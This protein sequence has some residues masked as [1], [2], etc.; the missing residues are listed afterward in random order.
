[1]NIHVIKKEVRESLYANRGLWMILAS[2]CILSVLCI[3]VV[4]IKEGSVLAQSD[5]LQYFIKASLFITLF[6]AMVLGASSF[7]MEREE[8]TLESLLLTP[9]SKLNLSIAK[10]I[11]VLMVGF[12]LLLF[13]IPYLIAVGAG[14]GLTLSA[15]LIAFFIGVILLLAFSAISVALSVILQSS[16][17]AI[18]TSA[19]VLLILSFPAFVQSLLKQSPVGAAL[20]KIDPVACCFGLMNTAFID[21]ISIFAMPQYCLPPIIFAVIAI[22]LLEWSSG[23]VALKGEK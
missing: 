20:L 4:N 7:A 9:I 13:S 5:L 8:H 19:L 10:Y 6:V 18:L 16:K 21:K 11:G 15:L 12:I 2:V 14:S 3:V 1:M 22:V 17:A 23:K